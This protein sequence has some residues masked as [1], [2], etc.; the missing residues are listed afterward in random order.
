MSQNETYDFA[1]LNHRLSREEQAAL[2]AASSRATITATRF[3]NRY[4]FGSFKGNDRKWMSKYFDIH[5]Y[6]GFGTLA[7]LMI[8]VP[9]GAMTPSTWKAYLVKDVVDGCISGDDVVVSLTR[10]IVDLDDQDTPR[11]QDRFYDEAK[12]PWLDML[13]GVWDELRAGDWRA[14]YLGWLVAVDNGTL[15]SKTLEAPVPPGL[16]DLSDAQKTLVAFLSIP[17]ALLAAAARGS[18]PRESDN[19]RQVRAMAWARGLI[20]TDPSAAAEWLSQVAIGEGG[21]DIV[22]RF[23]QANCALAPHGLVYNRRTV[24]EL[25]QLA[26]ANPCA[27]VPGIIRLDAHKE[28]VRL[29]M[30]PQRVNAT[31]QRVTD[32]SASSS[33]SDQ[34]IRTLSHLRDG[35]SLLGQADVFAA[36]MGPWLDDYVARFPNR[37]MLP[38]VLRNLGVWP[39]NGL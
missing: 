36:R 14:L 17:A 5:V 4:D 19:S 35:Y 26:K 30:E 37:R 8:R 28:S 7:K 25:R 3:T 39:A 15:S 9:Q 32:M 22:A 16:S 2:R 29:L 24:G 38:S 18:S 13:T 23:A 6:E 1:A 34:I 12:H 20:N 21:L 31:W 33:K 27:E 10:D 11:W